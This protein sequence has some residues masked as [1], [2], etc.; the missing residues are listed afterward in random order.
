MVTTLKVVGQNAELELQIKNAKHDTIKARLYNELAWEIKFSNPKQSV[1]YAEKAIQMA[2]RFRLLE[3]LS[4]GYKAKAHGYLIQKMFIEGL[5]F[6]DSSIYYA[7]ACK[8]NYLITV[9]LNKKA[10]AMGDFGNFDEAILLY[11]E[12]LEYALKSNN[13]KLKSALSNN[14][15]DAYQNV[16]RNTEL[17]QKYFL[18]AIDYALKNND[19]G[20]A[21]LSSAN[22]AKEYSLQ[23]QFEKAKTE[24]LRTLKLI[25]QYQFRDYLF[26]ATHDVISN[27]YEDVNEL[28]LAQQYA[29]LSYQ[30]LD[31]LKMPD[32]LLRPLLV[33]SSVE[34]KL[35]NINEAKQ[36]TNQMLKL[37][38]ERK[39]KVFIKES[40]RLLSEIANSEQQYQKALDYFKLYKSWNDSVFA[41]ERGRN[42][43]ALE[44]KANLEKKEIETQLALKTKEN[45]NKKLSSDV[46]GLKKG[47]LLSLIGL[48]LVG[49]I[50]FFLY[51]SNKN[52]QQ[53]N[54]ELIEKNK[55]VEQQTK[56]KEVLIQEIHHRVKNNLTMLQSLLYLQSKTS[57]HSQVKSV[58]AESQTRILSM[59][60]VHQHLYENDREGTLNLVEFLNS[61]LN[62]ISST[63]LNQSHQSIS[64]KATG[65][66]D[67]I[68]IKLAVPLG[69]IVNELITNSLKYAFNEIEKGEIHIDVSQTKSQI[70][71]RYSDNGPGLKQ[72]FDLENN[73][74]GFKI[75]NL[76]IKQINATI[77]YQSI[78][79]QHCFLI[80]VLL[81]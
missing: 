30:I 13:N 17:T 54:I 12:G 14:L 21:S 27:V 42:I 74:F 20:G 39:A 18:M 52:K 28:K 69:L 46:L 24:L 67:D 4:N 38:V 44:F 56:D 75:I 51:Q 50:V 19:I 53:F 81:K 70:N 41:A 33:L 55:I 61:L 5:Q 79:G 11:T 43:A 9:A 73:G 78:E 40:Y 10:G 71:I 6:Y 58:L 2:Y 34:L 8:N 62:E 26:G 16:N 37:S 7:K 35:G 47:I 80:G 22:L 63:F 68:G 66:C 59:A 31:S 76:L 1:E 64:F 77:E 57:A 45:I 15:A 48:L 3:Q 36:L 23:K 29:K 60:L 65:T 32:N 25:N 72:A 49:I